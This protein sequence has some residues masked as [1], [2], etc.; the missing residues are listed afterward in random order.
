MSPTPES[1]PQPP[2]DALIVAGGAVIDT[3]ELGPALERLHWDL[4]DLDR[5][6]LIAADSGA[7]LALALGLMPD[8]VIGDMDSI[9]PGTLSLLEH[10]GVPIIRHPRDKDRTDLELALDHTAS[11]LGAR[12]GEISRSGGT[13]PAESTAGGPGVPGGR[14][15]RTTLRGET[16]EDAGPAARVLV[17]GAGGGRLDHLLGNLAVLGAP[18]YRPLGLVMITPGAVVMPVGPGSG[19][20]ILPAGPGDTVTLLALGG[21]AVGVTTRGLRYPLHDD[22]LAADSSLGLSNVVG[23]AVPPGSPPSVTV[24]RGTVLVVI[25]LTE[26]PNPPRSPSEAP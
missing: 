14:S 22:V 13:A 9:S 21:P 7:E 18:R 10:R 2:L 26:G 25:P 19:G 4:G 8:A 3:S 11:L 15:A 24:A 12:S 20:R 23:P 1:P 5:V 16:P 17:L 6:P